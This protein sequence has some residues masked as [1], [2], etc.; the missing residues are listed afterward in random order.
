MA[1]MTTQGS[2]KDGCHLH[3]IHSEMKSF[4]NSQMCGFRPAEDLEYASDLRKAP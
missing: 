3:T 2:G 4:I 1:P